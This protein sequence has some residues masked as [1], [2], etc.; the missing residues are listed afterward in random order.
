MK[1][2]NIVDTFGRK[3]TYL[4]ISLTERCN[5][6]CVYCMPPQGVQ[7][8]PSA[9]IMTADEIFSI[10]Q[11]FV[12]MGVTKIRL[13][14]GEPLLRKDFALILEKLGTLNIA[15]GLS[16][17]GI[18]LDKY[19]DILKKHNVKVN[20]SLDTLQEEKFNTITRGDYMNKVISNIYLLERHGIAAKINVVV[21]K[22]TN[23]DEVLDFVDLTKK[24]GWHIRFIEYM[25]FKD[26]GWNF[27]KGMYFK[28]LYEEINKHYGAKNIIK[29]NDAANDTAKNY[30]IAGHKG[31]FGMIT[32][33][34]NPF[35]D[36]CNRIRLT[37]NGRIK[38]CLFSQ[39]ETDLLTA[40]RAGKDIKPL[41]L[42]SIFSK[43]KATGGI[44]DFSSKESASN[45][46]N[47]RS[48]I[49]IGG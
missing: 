22:G 13:S 27:E 29:L 45:I 3:H 4:R 31:S 21:I 17:N 40:F 5:L 9:S 14:G 16:T 20:V 36:T 1:A 18:L 30:Q 33:I 23:D 25:P 34:T 26:N 10:A 11:T 38:N 24:I 44:K 37:A 6:R 47:N 7:L 49:L 42:Q 48:M 12:S 2:T 41:I 32:T 43:S 35:C 8:S 28:E 46:E 19:F 39:S 15:L